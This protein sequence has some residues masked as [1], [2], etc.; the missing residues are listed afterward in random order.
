[1]LIISVT[2][3]INNLPGFSFCSMKW[4]QC[5]LAIKCDNQ[6]LSSLWASY[7]IRSWS[8]QSPVNYHI[9]SFLSWFPIKVSIWPNTDTA[10]FPEMSKLEMMVLN[11]LDFLA[12]QN[13]V[14][15]CVLP[16]PYLK[17]TT[18]LQLYKAFLA[19]NH[20]SI[21][22]I[23]PKFFDLLVWPLIS[24]MN[25]L[26]HFLWYVLQLNSTLFAVLTSLFYFISVISLNSNR[27]FI[28]RDIPKCE[29][30]FMS[31]SNM[32]G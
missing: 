26:S 29:E 10:S 12:P 21:L 27:C 31:I 28:S 11:D 24:T 23:L 13:R 7:L 3:A 6:T 17:T 22:M 14:G 9:L 5:R 30:K 20:F 32:S 19:L 8:H 2:W 25:F 15:A 1:M 16:F 4:T 18:N